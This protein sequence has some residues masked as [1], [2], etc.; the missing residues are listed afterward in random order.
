MAR[1]ASSIRPLAAV[2]Q[3]ATSSSVCTSARS[4]NATNDSAQQ[5]SNSATRA[6]RSSSSRAASSQTLTRVLLR[7][8]RGPLRHRQDLR[9]PARNLGRRDIR[10]LVDGAQRVVD[11]TARRRRPASHLLVGLHLRPLAQRHQR[12]RT[13]GIEPGHARTQLHLERGGALLGKWSVRRPHEREHLLEL[14][15]ELLQPVFE[16]SPQLVCFLSHDEPQGSRAT[17]VVAISS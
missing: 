6:R 11:P 10:L 4:R 3:R 8:G 15:A 1:N 2:D 12:L 17:G 14:L 9:R 7:L 13:P 5:A 16:R